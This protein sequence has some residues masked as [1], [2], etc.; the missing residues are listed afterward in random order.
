[1]GIGRTGLVGGTGSGDSTTEETF[2]LGVGNGRS[3]GG[4]E[5]VLP[6]TSGT[7]ADNGGTDAIVD[8][9]AAP[10]AA[11]GSTVSTATTF[12]GATAPVPTPILSSATGG[13][14]SKTVNKESQAMT[15]VETMM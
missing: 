14:T 3:T 2:S 5:D 13:G 6:S 8:N 1:M 10:P 12:S 11:S 4:G 15:T 7:L 9:P